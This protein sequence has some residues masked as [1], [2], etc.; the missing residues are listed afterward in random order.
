MSNWYPEEIAFL[1]QNLETSTS[2]LWDKYTDKFGQYRSQAAV[3]RQQLRLKSA[4]NV[5]NYVDEAIDHAI[6]DDELSL[7]ITIG[8]EVTSAVEKE[9][10]RHLT[11][12]KITP[13]T[14]QSKQ[15]LKD[16]VEDL[17]QSSKSLTKKSFFAPRAG[18]SFVIHLSDTHMGKL[19]DTFDSNVFA[20]RFASIPSK[21]VSEIGKIPDL[22]EIVLILAGDMVEGEDIYPTQ[23]SHIE[24]PAI[25]Q[26]KKVVDNTL[27]LAKALNKQF[28]VLVRIVTVPGNHGRV[29][30][31]ASEVTNFDNIVYQTLNYVVDAMN[32]FDNIVMDCNF[33]SFHI[34]PVQDKSV[35]ITH[36]GTKHLGTP[37]MQSKVAGWI[38]TKEFDMA[39]HGHWHQWSVDAQFGK[40]VMKNGSLP[41]PDDLSERMGVYDPPR[42]GWAIIRTGQPINQFGFFE[43]DLNEKEDS[44]Y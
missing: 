35:L 41:G 21:M 19:T 34:F 26:I 38:H 6:V 43:W 32:D 8:E 31:S 9:L 1:K 3:R 22:E 33:D 17:I 15:E 40:P 28:G 42:Q 27:L 36:H 5:K 30:K 25:I 2:E 18:C 20:S 39:F 23:N 12:K 24:M 4:L 37:A 10:R 7:D 11:G 14:N 44:K 13:V 16:F 29:S